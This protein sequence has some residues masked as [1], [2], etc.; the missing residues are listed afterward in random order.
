MPLTLQSGKTIV[1]SQPG[2]LSHH[3]HE[4]PLHLPKVT[5]DPHSSFLQNVTGIKCR[6]KFLP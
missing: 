4:M 1:D 5:Y 2:Y 3:R 6:S